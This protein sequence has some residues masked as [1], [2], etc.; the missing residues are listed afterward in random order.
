M[1]RFPEL[2]AFLFCN[3]GKDHTKSPS[4]GHN[5]WTGLEGRLNAGQAIVISPLVASCPHL[6][7]S[8]WMM[9]LG[10]KRPTKA[11][12]YCRMPSTMELLSPVP[13][14]C[15]LMPSVQQPCVT[16]VLLRLPMWLLHPAKPGF[17]ISA[18]GLY[19]HAI[20]VLIKEIA[21]IPMLTRTNTLSS[22][23]AT[24]VRTILGITT[25]VIRTTESLDSAPR[26]C[27]KHCV[28]GL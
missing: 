19:K 23:I 14:S 25:L 1:G 3:T 18:P 13:K 9:M 2:L 22:C 4:T 16:T 12:N 24:A 26:P 17:A 11:W 28:A 15:R 20:I 6:A 10:R 27:I 5:N 8:S 21:A 7:T